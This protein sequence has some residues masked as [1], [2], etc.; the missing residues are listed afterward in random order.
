MATP[1]QI[2]A[3]I[4][5]AQ[6]STRPRTEAGKATSSRNALKHG[7]TAQTVLLLGEDEEAYRQ[8]RSEF[9]EGRLNSSL[10]PK[11]AVAITQW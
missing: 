3:N 10:L 9:F 6:Q 4:V 11:R 7:L 8:L 2:T 1:A 5:N